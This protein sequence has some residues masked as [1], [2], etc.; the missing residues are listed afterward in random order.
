MLRTLVLLLALANVLTW[1][2]TQGFLGFLNLAPTSQREPERLAQ[3][4]EP[5][6]LRLLPPSGPTSDTRPE[7]SAPPPPPGSDPAGGSDTATDTPVAPATSA[8]ACWQASGYSAAQTIVLNAAL[9]GLRD[10]A[11]RWTLTE[12]LLPARWIVYLGPFPNATVLQ[13]RRAELRQAGVDHREVQ[14]PALGPG[15]A[16]GTF[17]N[18]EGA[19]QALR[20]LTRSGVSGARV[21]QE[22][23]DSRVFTLRLP[24][25]TDAE[26]AQVESLGVPLANRPLERCP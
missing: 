23:P 4:V 10:L 24:A 16:L 6:R 8:T 14:I 22:R 7:S 15:L 19:R 12:G 17:S 9:Q 3:Q 2:Y 5:E 13:R 1:A 18:E 26:R 25:I 11:G 20:Q 21:V